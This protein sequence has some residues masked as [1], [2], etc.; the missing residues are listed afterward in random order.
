M[1]S[2]P[3]SAPRSL[4]GPL[5]GLAYSVYAALIFGV[6]TSL[7]ICPLILTLPGIRRRRR[8]GAFGTRLGLLLMAVP[9]VVR[10]RERLPP[11]PCIVVANHASYLDGLLM[12]AAVPPRFTFVIQHG[13]ADWFYAGRVLKRMDYLF[14]NRENA[15][16]GAVQTRQM[17]KALQQG[18][19]LAIFAE[20]TFKDDPGLLAFKNGAFML[21]RKAGVPVVPA[22]IRGSRRLLGGGRW[23]LLWSWVE[24]E[25]GTPIAPGLPVAELRDAARAQVLELCGEPDLAPPAATGAGPSDDDAEAD[26]AIDRETDR[27]PVHEPVDSPRRSVEAA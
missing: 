3:S 25:F 18:E 16:A 23:R 14:V 17:L 5:F 20:G 4:F 2:R 27:S 1:H 8:L 7:L 11:G 19:S 10:G 13:A 26:R 24:V 12:T 22:A 9:F 6:V 15:R 21:A